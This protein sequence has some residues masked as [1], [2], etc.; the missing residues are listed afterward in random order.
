[1]INV[2]IIIVNHH[3][4]YTYSTVPS[5]SHHN[6]LTS[7]EKN[8]LLTNYLLQIY[9]VLQRTITYEPLKSHSRFQS[10]VLSPV[11]IPPGKTKH[12]KQLFS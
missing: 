5:K 6:F 4:L 12:T 8:G 11:L 1:M 2:Y 3:Y 7:F 10:V 9:N